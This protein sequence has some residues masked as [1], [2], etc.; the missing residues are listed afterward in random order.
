M[1]PKWSEEQLTAYRLQG[2]VEVDALVAKVLPKAGSESIG[3]FGYNEMLLLTDQLINNPELAFIKDSKLSQH[4]DEIPDD[5]VQYFKPMEAPD[6]VDPKKLQL[7]SSLWQQ[8]TLMSLGV[9]YSSSL[10]A[11]YLIKNGIAALYQS[12]KLREKQ[13][14]FQRI[15]ETGVMLATTMD[16]GG[17]S[18][19]DDAEYN[20]DKLLLDALKKLDPEGSWGQ[21]GQSC[22]KINGKGHA[23]LDP[24]DVHEEVAR[25][26]SNSK[27]YLWGKGYINAK[28]VRF[29]H[30]S[31]RYMLIQN[32]QSCPFSGKPNSF[33]DA[34]SQQ[35]SAWD[36]AK[37]GHPINQEDLAY[38][39]LTFG[40][41]IPKG[42]KNWGVPVS[43]AEREGFL[44]LWKVIGY[45]MGIREELLTDNWEEAEQLYALIA[46]RQVGHSEAGV[47]L[48]E[49][50]MGFL[51]DYLPDFPGFSEHISTAMIVNQLGVEQASKII[52]AENMQAISV[53]WR[54]PIFKSIGTVFK[55]FLHL[56]GKYY[57][58]FKHLGGITANRIHEAAEE[59]IKSWRS[60]YLRKP[61]FVPV[62]ATQWI[63]KPGVDQ[64]YINKLKSWRC[65]LLNTIVI[66]FALL[67]ISVF[68][69]TAALP[70]W[71]LEGEIAIK[72]CLTT[73][74]VSWGSFYLLMNNW[75]PVVFSKRPRTESEK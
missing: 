10:P 12:E 19:L 34:L 41:L 29:L 21:E 52:S 30:S 23:Q 14:I 58:R 3:T 68:S 51:N 18:L 45:T 16:P 38:T 72:I 75:L 4:L 37:F 42:L 74:L 70:A 9:L 8:N 60:A 25:L 36:F 49:S 39:L 24:Q 22:D 26:R 33:T 48:T 43:D 6:W 67:L 46:K 1:S 71:L 55:V 53:F 73:A 44:H 7:G 17:I 5:L 2:D 50:L 27:K 11:C 56:R 35:Q 64:D 63:R 61:F 54:R 15:Y 28:K 40:M 66:S 20:H 65:H 62:N 31:M 59:L 47:I 32:N 69:F 57:H 13:Y